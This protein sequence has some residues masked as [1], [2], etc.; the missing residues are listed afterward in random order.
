LKQM[1]DETPDVSMRDALPDSGRASEA[2]APLVY[3]FT[4]N[5]N[6][7][8]DTLACLESLA[9]L[10]YPHKRL[11]LVDNGSTDGTASAVAARFPEVAIVANERNLGF[12]AGANMGLRYALAEGAEY[13]FFINNDAVADPQMLNHLLAAAA[14]DVGMVAPKIFYAG[15]PRRIWSVGGLRHP[16]TGEQTGDARNMMDGDRWQDVVERDFFVGCA[17]LFSRAF[18]ETVGLYDERF[19][20]YYEDADLSWRAREAGFRLLLSPQAHVWHKVAGSSGGS[21]SPNERYWMA[22]SS[23]LYFHKHIHGWRWLVVVPYRSASA[24]K[25]VLR[26]LLRRRSAAARAYLR[27]L[28]DGLAELRSGR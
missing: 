12:A 3:A 6:R 9:G 20:M 13:I 17:V 2:G 23:V 28:R 8:D 15:E 14:P 7:R 11:L 21:D 10:D 18:L 1:R 25:T 22:R 24:L 5:W 19:F 27:G 4:L 26:L 16:W